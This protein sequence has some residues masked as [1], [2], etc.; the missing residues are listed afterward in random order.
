MQ[1]ASQTPAE[2]NRGANEVERLRCVL[3]RSYARM[4]ERARIAWSERQ[5]K[6]PA[7]ACVSIRV[8]GRDRLSA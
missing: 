4:R 3:D 2:V 7:D 6:D 5:E 8:G 1:L